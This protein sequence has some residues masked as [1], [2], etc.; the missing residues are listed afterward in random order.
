MKVYVGSPAVRTHPTPQNPTTIPHLDPDHLPFIM[1]MV[2]QKDE[3]VLQRHILHGEPAGVQRR[4]AAECVSHHVLAVRF[5]ETAARAG[6]GFK[7]VAAFR[8][9]GDDVVAEIVLESLV[10]SEDVVVILPVK[11]C[12]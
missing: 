12:R 11:E 1:V 3:H 9:L 6:Q 4:T 10:H 7:Q 5:G 2:T 8:E